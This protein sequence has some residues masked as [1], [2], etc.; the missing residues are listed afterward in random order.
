MGVDP[1]TDP[2]PDGVKVMVL[3]LPYP[4]Q[5]VVGLTPRVTG[6]HPSGY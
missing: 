6:K 3:E 4:I 2:E 5:S 1:V